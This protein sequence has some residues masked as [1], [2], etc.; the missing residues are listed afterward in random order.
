MKQSIEADPPPV[1]REI[2]AMMQELRHLKGSRLTSGKR[3][4]IVK[5]SNNLSGP[6]P[7]GEKEAEAQEKRRLTVQTLQ[8]DPGPT[9]RSLGWPPSIPMKRSWSEPTNWTFPCL[10]SGQI[11][12]AKKRIPRSG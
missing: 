10:R 3:N 12:L 6:Q 1:G 11:T 8:L 2:M 9:Q 7:D 5:G 4:C